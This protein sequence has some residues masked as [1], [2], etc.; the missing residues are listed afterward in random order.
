MEHLGLLDLFTK[1]PCY[2]VFGTL[3]SLRQHELRCEVFTCYAKCEM[4]DEYSIFLKL[5]TSYNYN[6][7]CSCLR[8]M[9]KLCERIIYPLTTIYEMKLSVDSLC[10]GR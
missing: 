10:V 1:R 9:Y 2:I 6:T 4:T 8:K 5:G 3:Y 7:P